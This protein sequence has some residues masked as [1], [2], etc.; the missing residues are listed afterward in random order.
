MQ[1]INLN[2]IP[3]QA[4]LHKN[5]SSFKLNHFFY[6]GELQHID[7]ISLLAGSVY[8]EL[9]ELE[10]LCKTSSKFV[11][12][13][14]DINSAELETIARLKPNM[15]ICCNGF[16][17]KSHE[18]LAIKNELTDTE[19]AAIELISSFDLRSG[20]VASPNLK[21]V[22]S[23]GRT[24][25]DYIMFD[26]SRINSTPDI[27][28]ETELLAE[29]NLASIAASKL[30]F[31][32]MLGGGLS[33]DNLHLY[34]ELENIEEFVTSAQLLDMSIIDGFAKSIQRIRKMIKGL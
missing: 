1:R 17:S 23:L 4:Y 9:S 24:A 21:F 28:E 3:F 6:S 11:V 15:I 19:H 27:E 34:S 33:V 30:G 32:I 7:S 26:T 25:I 16:D 10:V 31:G 12:L 13:Y 2:L 20:I 18:T 8:T 29:L 5:V 22:K 14:C